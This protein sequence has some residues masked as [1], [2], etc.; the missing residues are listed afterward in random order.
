MRRLGLA[1]L[2]EQSRGSEV[3]KRAERA[4]ATAGGWDGRRAR[5]WCERRSSFISRTDEGAARLLSV[6]LWP[7]KVSSALHRRGGAAPGVANMHG[8]GEPR[9]SALL[10]DARQ[11]APG[12]LKSR[13]ARLER[14][15]SEAAGHA[16]RC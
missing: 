10:S 2:R 5:C 14:S 8:K 15:A 13:A 12:R 1:D 9:V 4:V 3:V 7:P 11:A 16:G 6:A